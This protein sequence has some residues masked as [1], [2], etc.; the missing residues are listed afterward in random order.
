MDRPTLLPAMILAWVLLAAPWFMMMP[1]MG[2]GIAGSRTPEPNIARLRSVVN[3][4][5]F[6][7]G[8]Y[9]TAIALARTWPGAA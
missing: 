4:S 2:M 3:H 5:I 6:G 1:G 9:A 8:M 7:L